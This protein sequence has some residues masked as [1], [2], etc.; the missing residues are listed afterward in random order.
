MRPDLKT[1]SAVAMSMTADRQATLQPRDS[2][3]G[4]GEY[5]AYRTMSVAAV[6]AC[7]LGI[8]SIVALAD[9]WALKAIPA[10]GL[11]VGLF[12]LRQLAKYPDELSGRKAALV[13]VAA[14]AFFLAAGSGL[15]WWMYVAELPE[16]YERIGYEQLKSK[17]GDP[18]AP[19]A[20][21]VALDG[22]RVF[23]KG[24]MYQPAYST[25]IRRFVLCRD[26]GDCCFG[27]QPP[28]SDM[29]FVELVDPLD[30]EFTSRVR[31]VAGTFRVAG[32]RSD[33]VGQVVLYRLEADYIK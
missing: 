8:V 22:K 9:Y 26:N 27:G 3:H 24:Y 25:G 17:S 7:V 18:N 21:A 20:E 6:V 13:G 4:G 5:E 30:T 33:D 11:V 29:V 12:A 32:T 23:I 2:A 28:K 10:L 31:K 15:S 14:S 16:G 1:V 19:S